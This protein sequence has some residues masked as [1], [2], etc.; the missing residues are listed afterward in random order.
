M[1]GGLM[2]SGINGII[3]DIIT[4]LLYLLAH[5]LSA[6]AQGA[7]LEARLPWVSQAVAVSVAVYGA[8]L[9]LRVAWAGLTEYVL[10]SESSAVQ[11]PLIK[12]VFRSGAY[13]ALGTWLAM[14][15]FKWGIGLAGAF[16]AAP[17][18]GAVSIDHSVWA[19]I[20]TLA[21]PNVGAVLLLTMAL[22]VGLVMIVI[23]AVQM[24]IRGAE[25]VFFVVAAPLV[26][27]GHLS[28]GGG[29][30]GSW[31]RSLVVLSLSQ[32]VQWLGIKGMIAS[33]QVMMINPGAG[34][35]AVLDL[36]GTAAAQTYGLDLAVL[37]MIGWG[38]AMLRGPHLVKEWS[39]RSGLG[40]GASTLAGHAAGFGAQ[41]QLKSWFPTKG[42]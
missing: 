2:L 19:D 18:A 9:T 7:V 27:L 14:A 6:I 35:G 39:Y 42:A 12:R 33:A 24:A 22:L 32:A 20:S 37:F 29:A 3:S 10:F 8:L 30:W 16:L 5:L 41:A 4:G 34:H 11:E 13:A 36:V 25:L 17:L 40:S 1:V 38:V 21:I 28:Q 31:W 15:T 26:A 23:V